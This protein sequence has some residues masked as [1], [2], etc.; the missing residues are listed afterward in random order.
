MESWSKANPTEKTFIHSDKATYI[1]GESI[2]YKT[3]VTLDGEPSF[4]SKIVYVDLVDEKGKVVEKKMHPLTNGS[5][6]GNIFLP[7]NLPTGNYSLNAYTLWM[8]NY[9]PF[10]SKKAI[11]I[12]SSD[13]APAISQASENDFDVHLFPEG[14]EM[15]HDLKTV[16]AV[17][18]TNKKGMPVAATGSVKDKSGNLVTFAT[19]HNGYGKF[20]MT[21][22][23]NT[24]VAVSIKANGMEKRIT[25]P[26]AKKEGIV[27]SVNNTSALRTFVQVR[28]TVSDKAQYNSLLVVAQM[29]GKPVFMGMV[30][31]NEDATGMAIP[32]K[33]LP[34]GI[35]QITVFDVNAVP[36][37]ERLVFVN[38]FD[39]KDFTVN[40][41][42]ISLAKRGKNKYSINLSQYSNPSLSIAITDAE[43]SS[44]INSD[45]N[46]VS[47]LFLT[48]DLKGYVH[49]SGYYLQNKNPDVTA[50]LDLL[51]LTHGWRRFK[52]EDV[53]NNNP[54]ALKYPVESGISLSGIVTIPQS[55]KTIA[56][57]HVDIITKGEDSTTILSKAVVN[58]KGHFFINDLNF[59]QRATVYLQGSKTSNMNANVDII[60]NK[61]YIDTLRTSENRTV[62]DLDTFTANDAKDK[63]LTLLLLETGKNKNNVLEGVT[64]RAKKI[65][66]VD[67]LNNSYASDLFQLGQ[68]LELT[69][70]HYFNIWQFL[71]EQVSG[72]TV[73]GDMT[74]PNVYFNRNAGLRLP[75]S[76]E[77]AD[78]GTN[79][80]GGIE[81]NGISYYLNEINVSK[82][83]IN[84]L[85]PTDIAL[86]KI[87]K[88]PE[89]AALGITEG[90]IALYTKK[91]INTKNRVGEKGFFTENKLGYSV[92]REFFNPDYS[93]PADSAFTD[94]RTT[95]YWNGNV[96][97]N[98]AGVATIK[99]FNNDSAK[100]FKIVIQGIDKKGE[101]LFKEMIVD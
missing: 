101:L 64:V 96:I 11:R 37:A 80:A 5:S 58:D 67:S 75:N 66:R 77:P 20:E 6:S 30:N 69:S 57:G 45:D 73:E 17:Y 92:I 70:A 34:P 100:K 41:D 33:N 59:K 83:V 60:L 4:L 94:N 9:K 42:S 79:D 18:V 89:G 7:K 31:F 76:V 29:Y 44:G 72:L 43:I 14:G 62:V 99:F 46:I 47:N 63:L 24:P 86:V 97:T 1:S 61:T 26:Q 19:E 23:A 49:Q 10:L 15:V 56:G 22:D 2:W 68:S 12:Y 93:M 36:L 39:L 40:R 85:H 87:F 52:W 50:H 91:G 54:V 71:R 53:L 25:L 98:S 48:S 38:N 8:L 84:T 90:G 81:E 16:V 51:M 95:L 88:G 82:D 13:Y 32:K 35:M 21:A 28:R 55:K 27:M 78:D 74:N 3:Y 65:S